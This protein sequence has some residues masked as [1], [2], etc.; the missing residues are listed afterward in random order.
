MTIRLFRGTGDG[1]L[2]MAQLITSGFDRPARWACCRHVVHHTGVG[3]V[4][5]GSTGAEVRGR[6]P[7]SLA[8][9][10]DMAFVIDDESRH[11]IQG[12]GR[13]V[14]DGVRFHEKDKA[15]GKDV[16]RMGHPAGSRGVLGRA[17]PQFL[18]APFM[19]AAS[20]PPQRDPRSHPGRPR[21][22]PELCF[23]V[24]RWAPSGVGGRRWVTSGGSRW[25]SRK[26][27][28]PRPRAQPWRAGASRM[29]APESSASPRPP[30]LALLEGQR[31]VAEQVTHHA[32]TPLVMYPTR[33]IS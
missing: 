25:D 24:R 30:R 8:D 21:L 26:R 32:A 20:P 19:L 28:R 14:G 3:A 12:S 4:G 31:R 22:R 27:A 16:P 29:A 7:R 10:G 2:S 23:M 5:D 9:S 6:P 18:T 13:V 15:N 17:D 33:P 11:L 1:A